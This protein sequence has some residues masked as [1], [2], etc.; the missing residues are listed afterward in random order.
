MSKAIGVFNFDVEG[1]SF[2]YRKPDSGDS[3][4]EKVYFRIYVSKPFEEGSKIIIGDTSLANSA[5]EFEVIG[6]VPYGE[7]YY[8]VTGSR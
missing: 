4:N 1:N 7:G 3:W 8:C 5:V 6:C 2:F